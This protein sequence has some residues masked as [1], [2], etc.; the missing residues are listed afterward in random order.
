MV[1]GDGRR[2]STLAEAVLSMGLGGFDD[3]GE[4]IEECLLFF[5]K[6]AGGVASGILSGMGVKA[7]KGGRKML[8]LFRRLLSLMTGGW[9]ARW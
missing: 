3:S 4:R 7:A 1:R 9:W 5:F 6:V 2:S 8:K